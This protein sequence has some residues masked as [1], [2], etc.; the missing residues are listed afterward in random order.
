[1]IPLG[2]TISF[3]FVIFVS[4]GV[5]LGYL[6]CFFRRDI[7]ISRLEKLTEHLPNIP[8]QG[9]DAKGKVF[10]W[11]RASEAAYGYSSHQAL[12]KDI[13]ELIIPENERT[14]FRLT[15]EEVCRG[16]KAAKARESTV[17]TKSAIRKTICATIF[18]QMNNGKCTGIFSIDIDI[19]ALKK[20]EAVLT[21]ALEDYKGIFD[22]INDAVFVHDP[23]SGEILEVNTK[24]CELFEYPREEVLKLSLEHISYGDKDKLKT[25]AKSL[26]A[27]AFCEGPQIFEWMCLAKTGKIFPVE[28]GLKK[29]RIGKRDC[30]FATVRD[31]SDEIKAYDMLHKSESRYRAV[32]EDQLEL[33]CRFVPGG[34][35]TFVNQAYCRFF[36]KKSEEFI[37]KNFMFYVFEEEKDKVEKSINS[38][39]YENQIVTFEQQIKDK[40]GNAY[41]LNW[42]ARA[43]FDEK[44]GLLEYQAIGRDVTKRKYAEV[45]LKDSEQRYQDLLINANEIIFT[46]DLKGKLTSVNRAVNKVLGLA[47]QD[48][49]G[50]HFAELLIPEEREKIKSI[51]EAVIK[52]NERKNDE[53]KALTRD[54]NE[55]FL[56][57]QLWPELRNDKL[58]GVYG[59]AA[60]FTEQKCVLERM[61]EMVIQIVSMLSQTVA[62]ADRYTE[63]HCE[64]LQELALKIGEKLNLSDKELENLKFAALLHDVGK[65]GIPI[66]ILIKKG[67]LTEDEWQKIKQHPKKGADIIRQL[68]GFEEV[69]QIIEQHQERV[70]GKGYPHGLDKDRIRKEATIISVVDAYDAMTSD[71]PYRKAMGM[72]QAIEELRRNAGTQF[73]SDVVE[74]FI[75]IIKKNA[76]HKSQ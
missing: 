60:D 63:Q 54:G 75:E 43:L 3:C 10:F 61:R 57:V 26:I 64:R 51:F 74:A 1:M 19:A 6:F 24:M 62:V 65:V 42:T 73:D 27:K 31:I 70:D 7:F 4:A 56:R 18:P 66:N 41:W 50:R 15:L 67:E 2:L 59:V 38:I 33:I 25:R 23:D 12:G 49:V 44:N 28:I 29:G 20:Q 47:E 37:G 32:V 17:V 5:I 35:L 40:D 76:A 69:A 39:T 22:G 9:F 53:L 14:K 8:I 48:V 13:A 34:I 21:S 55:C 11:S 30:V 58:I 52:G 36:D 46:C 68:S 16:G 71:R 45:N 72:E